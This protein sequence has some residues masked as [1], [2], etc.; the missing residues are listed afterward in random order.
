M[1]ADDARQ[2]TSLIDLFLHNAPRKIF[3]VL[4]LIGV[5]SWSVRDVITLS[6][7]DAALQKWIGACVNVGSRCRMEVSPKLV[8]T[9]RKRQP[10]HLGPN[11]R[12]DHR[13]LRGENG[14]HQRQLICRLRLAHLHP[15]SD[16]YRSA[17][18]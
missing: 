6:N 9:L 4:E 5:N 13:K 7:P 1:R 8:L 15:A 2:E 14:S 3:S 11:W 18:T 12:F 10:T 17:T 16:G